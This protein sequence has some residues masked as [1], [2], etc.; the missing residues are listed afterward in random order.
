MIAAAAL[1][2]AVLGILPVSAF[3]EWEL[4]R[5][6]R[7]SPLRNTDNDRLSVKFTRQEG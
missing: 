1:V 4:A 2:G 7:Y 5:L 3:Y 6:G